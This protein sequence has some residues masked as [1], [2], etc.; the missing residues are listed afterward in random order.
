MT[1]YWRTPL[2]PDTELLTAEYYEQE[3]AP[4]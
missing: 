4:H 3:F 2:L 1:R